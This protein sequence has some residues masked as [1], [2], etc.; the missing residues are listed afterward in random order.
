[1][2]KQEAIE[3][4]ERWLR[5]EGLEL[6]VPGGRKVDADVVQLNAEGWYVP[7]NTTEG[8]DTGDPVELIVPF[9]AFIVTEPDGE[10]RMANTT[11]HPGFSTPLN[12]P[13]EPEISE[14]IDPEYQEDALYGLGVPKRRVAGWRI[15]HPDGRTEE[16]INPN[17]RPG[18]RRLGLPRCE[19]RL[20]LILNYLELKEVPRRAFLSALMVGDI[21]IP[22]SA[23]KMPENRGVLRAVTSRRKLGDATSWWRMNGLTF[24]ANYPNCD[25]KINVDHQPTISIQSSE[26]DAQFKH[27]TRPPSSKIM[28]P[29]GIQPG[30]PVFEWECGLDDSL[31]EY[32]AELQRRFGLREAPTLRF[33]FNRVL[34]ARESGYELTREER[35]RLLL[36]ASWRSSDI[37]RDQWPQ[38]LH[39]NGLAVRHDEAGEEHLV[40]N[41]CGKFP[42]VGGSDPNISWHGV[43]GSF[44][45]FAIGEALGAAVDGLTWPQ[46]QERYGPHGIQD[47]DVVFERPGQAGW[48]T[49]LL[50]FRAEGLMRGADRSGTGF[51][52]EANCSAYARWL[53][54]QGMPWQEAAGSLAA[55]HPDPGGWL[56]R[57]PELHAHRGASPQLIDAVRAATAEPWRNPLAGPFRMI[58]AVPQVAL[59]HSGTPSGN[60]EQVATAALKS[61]LARLVD[62]GP[63]M[64]PIWMQTS[65]VLEKTLTA[66]DDPVVA[67][68]ADVV[69]DVDR[70][71]KTYMSWDIDNMEQLGDGAG[72]LSVFGRTLFAASRREYDPRM[73]LGVAVNH[74]GRSA[75]TGALAGALIGARAG[76]AGLPEEWVEAL[77]LRDVLEEVANDLYWHFS[78]RNPHEE[79]ENWDE[80]YPRW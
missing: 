74:T 36:G 34:Q 23:D 38:N 15:T 45:G 62:K 60:V 21:F 71:W 17:Y 64:N 79:R 40:L 5:A 68:V 44:V 70:R 58:G 29:S 47:L 41:T 78:R 24:V 3:L 1:M 22:G 27:F 42:L 12:W 75:L 6:D 72:T 18:P 31:D 9:P 37:T 8:V 30:E 52:P 7:I 35:E 77:D 20:E 50:L 59:G 65:T 56:V 61:I 28:S 57:V 69:R 76:V 10:L 49:Q 14:I 25:L 55:E 54:T 13:G 80:R 51:S 43:V 73:A 26:L 53:V 16:K 67:Q 19:N 63:W 11:P 48:L 46:I 66:T 4:V 2:E 39:A 33:Y 32:G